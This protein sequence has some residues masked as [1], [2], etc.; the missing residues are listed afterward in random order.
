MLPV[1]D[2]DD[3]DDDDDDVVL[4]SAVAPCYCSLLSAL[5]RVVSLEL[6]ACCQWVL[7]SV[8]ML[9]WSCQMWVFLM[10]WAVKY[11]DRLYAHG[12]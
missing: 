3:D 2:D 6:E 4:Y 10:N 1:G 8:Q 12:Y 5:G 9:V 7:R 11:G